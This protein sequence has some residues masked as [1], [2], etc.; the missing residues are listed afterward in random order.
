MTG[1]EA[2]DKMR[3]PSAAKAL[4]RMM[5]SCSRREYCRKE[6]AAK[7]ARMDISDSERDG[8]MEKLCREKYIDEQRYA[9]AFA[10]D[11]SRLQGW[12]PRKISF[13][14]AAKGIERDMIDAA[15]GSIDSEASSAKLRA[16]VGSKMRQLRKAGATAGESDGSLG[17]GGIKPRL[18]RFAMGRGYS[19]DQ[20]LKALSEIEHNIDHYGNIRTD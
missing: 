16:L 19:Y 9:S 6:I 12:G 13:A 14:L 15:L 11:K 10:R 4:D 2:A 20:I 17:E 3:S 7:L 8:I 1:K 5:A 18:L